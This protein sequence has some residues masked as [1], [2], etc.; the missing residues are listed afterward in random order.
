MQEV[1]LQRG[2]ALGNLENSVIKHWYIQIQA[3]NTH[4]DLAI[5][6]RDRVEAFCSFIGLLYSR[7]NPR[8]LA[9]VS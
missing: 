9:N 8:S 5:H 2:V 6:S 7:C 3:D 4:A 1:C